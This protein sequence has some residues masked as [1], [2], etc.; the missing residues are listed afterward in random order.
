MHFK[1]NSE[2]QYISIH[3]LVV[4]GLSINIHNESGHEGLKFPTEI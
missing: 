1:F 4:D 2:N 3:L